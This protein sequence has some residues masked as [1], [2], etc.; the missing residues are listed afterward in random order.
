MITG[1]LD[2]SNHPLVDI[3]LFISVQESFILSSD[4]NSPVTA[5]LP[6]ICD[7]LLLCPS[8]LCLSGS[9]M[10]TRPFELLSIHNKQCSPLLLQELSV[11]RLCLAA[12]RTEKWGYSSSPKLYVTLILT[13]VPS[14][15][16]HIRRMW[17]YSPHDRNNW[18]QLAK[19]LPI[20]HKSGPIIQSS[21]EKRIPSRLVQHIRLEASIPFW[22]LLEIHVS[23][24]VACNVKVLK[25]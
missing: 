9:L 23:Q 2:H 24:G 12:L 8:S 11:P 4:N 20:A 6:L 14:N 5:Y 18:Q 22:I 17:A 21:Q 19:F 16:S 10:T 15:G 25:K 13:C 3:L 1:P 7:F